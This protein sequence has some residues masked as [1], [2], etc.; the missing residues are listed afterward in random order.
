MS[1]LKPSV[2]LAAFLA[3]PFVFAEDCKPGGPCVSYY[4]EVGCLQDYKPNP[5]SFKP[6]PG[7]SEPNDDNC[8]KW[9][10]FKSVKLEA[11]GETDVTCQMWQSNNCN[12]DKPAYMKNTPFEWRTD[13]VP[14][15]KKNNGLKRELCINPSM[16][17]P[18]KS[19]FLFGSMR[20]VVYGRNSEGMT[21]DTKG[22]VNQTE[23]LNTAPVPPTSKGG[24]APTNG[25]SSGP[26]SPSTPGMPPGRPIE[27]ALRK[28]ETSSLAQKDSSSMSSDG[29]SMWTGPNPMNPL[30]GAPDTATM[31][32]NGQSSQN[33]SPVA[34]LFR[35]SA[36]AR[37]TSPELGSV[38]EGGRGSTHGQP[39]NV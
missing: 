12:S 34:P 2:L 25:I 7:S 10:N 23:S 38:S 6:N 29:R 5:G 33:G 15:D 27:D 32:Q 22:A 36:G 17:F 31:P 37:S 20:C 35:G 16:N 1:S 13:F 28:G 39:P 21:V 18:K 11:D 30:N 8:F 19:P 14:P 26:G 9:E 24:V 3:I 4:P